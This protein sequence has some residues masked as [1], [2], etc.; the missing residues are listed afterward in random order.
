MIY[1][2]YVY[3]V[4]GD[5][6]A[7]TP[8]VHALVY[9][10]DVN[11]NVVSSQQGGA[12]VFTNGQG[13]FEL[14]VSVIPNAITVRRSSGAESIATAQKFLNIVTTWQ[15]NT[16]M[17]LIRTTPKSVPNPSDPQ[18]PAK[19]DNTPKDNTSTILILAAAVGLGVLFAIS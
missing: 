16:P 6:N 10:S 11:G 1:K 18:P 7:R 17:Q 5:T 15:V 2:G 13:Y 19:A 3:T 14:P 9:V 8:D 12:A 4:S